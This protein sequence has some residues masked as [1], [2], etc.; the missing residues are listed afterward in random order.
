MPSFTQ[1]EM[2]RIIILYILIFEVLDRR[3][4]DKHSCL[5]IFNERKNLQS[6]EKE[7]MIHL[8]YAKSKLF[9][10]NIPISIN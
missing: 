5:D 10:R 8:E 7:C 6:S 1:K 9:Y 3:L 2:Y 4:K